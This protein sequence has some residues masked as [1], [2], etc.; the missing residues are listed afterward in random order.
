MLNIIQVNDKKYEV[1]DTCMFD[2]ELIDSYLQKKKD[3]GYDELIIDSTHNLF[4]FC[5]VIEEA[6]IISETLPTT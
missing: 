5:R 2:R 1:L 3:W 6:Q 4:L